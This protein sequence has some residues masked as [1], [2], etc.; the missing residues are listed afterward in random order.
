MPGRLLGLGRT[1]S[2]ARAPSADLASDRSDSPHAGFRLP[3]SPAMEQLKRH[4]LA[5]L[6]KDKKKDKAPSNS[7]SPAIKPTE[8][9]NSLEVSI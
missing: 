8:P 5:A 1:N 3:Q 6:G 9:K 4:S 7:A 2:A